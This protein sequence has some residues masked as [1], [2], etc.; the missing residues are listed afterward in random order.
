MRRREFLGVLGGAAASWPF[1]VGAQQPERLR[2]IGVL[3]NLAENQQ[4]KA[5]ISALRQALEQFG[6]T[7]HRNVDRSKFAG[8]RAM[9]SLSQVRGGTNG[10]G[11]GR[12][13]GHW[14]AGRRSAPASDPHSS[15][16]VVAVVDPV[17]A[18]LS[19]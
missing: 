5:R 16:R 6:W 13:P 10:V 7:D 9:L 17:G 11:T 4:A 8:R 19:C 18:G 12:H 14:H 1:A 3:M 2:R 15:N